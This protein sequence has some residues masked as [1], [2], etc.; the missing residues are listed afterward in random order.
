MHVFV[1]RLTSFMPAHTSL[2]EHPIA[3]SSNEESARAEPKPS[4][5]PHRSFID[6]HFHAILRRVWG[7]GIAFGLHLQDRSNG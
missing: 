1:Q 5:N 2:L 7:D 4:A 6:P 3:R